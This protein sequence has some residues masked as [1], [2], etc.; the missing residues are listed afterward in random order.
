M[1]PRVL[2]SSFR[3]GPKD[4]ARNLEI[5]VLRHPSRLFADLND[6]IAE[7]G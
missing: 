6:D 4:Q 2:I 1:T 5:P 7:L 3:D